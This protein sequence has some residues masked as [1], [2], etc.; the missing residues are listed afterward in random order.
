LKINWISTTDGTDGH[1]Y[2]ANTST[3]PIFFIRE[4]S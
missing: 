1:G 2:K 4:N 3:F